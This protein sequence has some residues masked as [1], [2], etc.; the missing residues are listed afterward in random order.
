MRAPRP[1]FTPVASDAEEL[2]L[3]IERLA[4]GGEGVGRASDGRV[5]FVPF[6]APGDRV[7]VRV[8]QQ[9]KRFVRA[10][11][12]ELLE[13]GAARTDPV[14]AVFGSCGGC[15]WQHVDYAAQLEAKCGIVADALTRIAGLELPAPIEIVPSPSPYAWRSR[16]R[17]VCES[18]R[19]GYRRRQSRALQAVTH[20]PVLVPD[21]DAALHAW[22]ASPPA[23]GEFELAQGDGAVRA[24]RLE[25]ARATAN[26]ARIG[27]RA[28]S[29][30]LE[31]SAGVFFQAH[32]G[33]RDALLEAALD[34]AGSGRVAADLFAGAGFFSLGLARRFERVVAVEAD[35]AA[36]ADLRQNAEAAGLRNLEV[37]EAPVERALPRVRGADVLLLD[38]PRTGLPRGLAEALARDAAS[39][40]V[41]VSCEPSTLARDLVAFRAGGLVPVRVT[42]FDLFPQTPHVEVL[43]RLERGVAHP[44]RGA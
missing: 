43:T 7:R 15:A 23:D 40:V 34:A 24:T 18:G 31:L 30:R 20:C 39:R 32:A 36:A 9:R 12:R 5:V 13:P 33:L 44:P 16:T 26:A 6:T 28:G 1:P 14:C 29:D 3:P 21:L 10:E 42:A 4:S 41:Y 35:P 2:E 11:V 19:I 37:V 22:A 17:L 25:D 38:P 27:L 8:T